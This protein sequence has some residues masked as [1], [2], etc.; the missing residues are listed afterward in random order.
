M[1]ATKMI[2]TREQEEETKGGD[3]GEEA[4]LEAYGDDL[5]NKM[6]ETEESPFVAEYNDVIAQ[7]SKIC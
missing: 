6:M 4:E 2:D 7:I 5:M 3:L 1:P